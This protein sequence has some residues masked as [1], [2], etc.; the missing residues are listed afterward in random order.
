MPKVSDAMT[1]DF[2][3]VLPTARITEVAE[4]IVDYGTSLIPIC[5]HGKLRGVVK[6]RDIIAFLVTNGDNPNR[7][8]V[9][10]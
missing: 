4:K 7:Y 2:A 9:A 6:E 5:D 10:C 1:R 3:P 8:L